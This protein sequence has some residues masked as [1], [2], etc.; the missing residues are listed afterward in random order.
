MNIGLVREHT[1]GFL[2]NDASCSNWMHVSRE[3]RETE[4]VLRRLTSNSFLTLL[5]FIFAS[6]IWEIPYGDCKL[7]EC[8]IHI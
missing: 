6:I 1:H 3:K 8:K 4:A 5:T 7:L 2:S